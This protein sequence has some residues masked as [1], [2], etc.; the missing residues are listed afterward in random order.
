MGEAPCV[1][2]ISRVN[3]EAKG[4]PRRRPELGFDRADDTGGIFDDGIRSGGATSSPAIG[5][6]TAAVQSK[7]PHILDLCEHWLVDDGTRADAC[8]SLIKSDENR[9]RI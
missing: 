7:P 2:E 8:P 1:E 5:A 6:A 4:P 9:E 3:A